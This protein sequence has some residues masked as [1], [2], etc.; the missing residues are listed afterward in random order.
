MSRHRRNGRL[1]MPMPGGLSTAGPGASVQDGWRRIATEVE[2]LVGFV[3]L[4]QRTMRI[5]RVLPSW[6]SFADT[7][8]WHRAK[9]HLF[10]E[11]R[12]RMRAWWDMAVEC[13]DLDQP[14]P[15]LR[16]AYC[17]TVL[18]FEHLARSG[19]PRME[20][21][22][23]RF[24]LPDEEAG[25]LKEHVLSQYGFLVAGAPDSEATDGFAPGPPT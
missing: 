21:D 3:R 19:H 4:Y 8:F 17:R 23:A 7:Q 6:A 10:P 11:Q 22:P 15:C 18:A 25:K 9:H 14:R 12:R 20:A 1:R 13:G 2:Q 5:G 24:N 16:F